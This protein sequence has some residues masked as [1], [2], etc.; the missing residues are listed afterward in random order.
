MVNFYPGFYLDYYSDRRLAAVAVWLLGSSLLMYVISGDIFGQITNSLTYSNCQLIFI[1]GPLAT[2]LTMVI[3]TMRPYHAKNP[4]IIHAIYRQ[5]N[6]VRQFRYCLLIL[7]LLKVYLYT[8]CDLGDF[9][10]GCFSYR[11]LTS[12]TAS[13]TIFDWDYSTNRTGVLFDLG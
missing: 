4:R 12:L 1:M 9:Q 6:S 7:S 5:A 8:C 13:V 10:A 3:T 2:P 11:T